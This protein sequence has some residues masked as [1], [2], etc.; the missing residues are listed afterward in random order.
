[1]K[2]F[3]GIVLLLLVALVLNAGLLAYAAYVLLGLLLLSRVLARSWTENLAAER[4][5]RI[6]G[7]RS[8]L[9]GEEKNIVAEVGQRVT[10][11]VTVRNTGNFPVPW[12]LI[13][14]L[15]PRYALDRRY[16][17]LRLKGKRLHLG[18]VRAGGETELRYSIECLQRGYYQIGPVVLENGDL[19]GL[20]RRFQVATEPRYL[21]VLP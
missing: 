1:M 9:Q 8:S 13:E 16:P 12:V 14:D 18:M 5:C 11:R 7:E 3:L 20:Y 17:R 15:L 2:W 4:S 21:L 10:I 6:A 19:F